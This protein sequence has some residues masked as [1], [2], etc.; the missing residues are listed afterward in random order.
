LWENGEEITPSRPIR[1][2]ASVEDRELVM[3]R[4]EEVDKET[5]KELARM[6]ADLIERLKKRRDQKSHE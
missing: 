3:N 4:A 6:K 2:S 1:E 5:A